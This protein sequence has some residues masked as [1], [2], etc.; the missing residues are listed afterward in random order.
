MELIEFENLLT[1]SGQ[2]AL[3][4]AQG[5]Y[6]R[7]NDYLTLYQKLNRIYPSDLSRCAL[8]IAILRNEGTK[9]FPFASELYFTRVALQQASSWTISTFRAERYREFRSIIDL[10]C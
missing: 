8:E 3:E 6:P 2:E 10:G 9:K 4:Y 7:E 1:P 5:L